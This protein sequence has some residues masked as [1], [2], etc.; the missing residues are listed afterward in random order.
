MTDFSY[1]R[2]TPDHRAQL[3]RIDSSHDGHLEYKP[4]RATLRSGVVHDRVF[5]VAAQPYFSIW[6]VWPEED[7]GKTSIPLNEVVAFTGSPFRLPAEFA[8]R[9]YRQ[10]PGLKDAF[11]F[12]IL[13]RDGT[14]LPVSTGSA[15]DFPRLPDGATTM[16]IVGI[17]EPAS[18]RQV[19]ELTYHGSSPD[20]GWCLYSE[21]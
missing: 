5:V 6:G 13:L 19:E 21:D 17:K 1:P 3:E 14:I 18:S 10:G 7:S 12:R 20:Y 9:L 8:D 2:L 11:V 16:D 15:V 4:C